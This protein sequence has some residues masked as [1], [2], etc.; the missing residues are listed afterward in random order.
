MASAGYPEKLDG[1]VHE[2][3]RKD[4]PPPSSIQKPRHF[5][6]KLGFYN[7]AVL[8]LG[9]AAVALALAF[10][11]FLWGAATQARHGGPFPELWFKIAEAGWMKQTVTVSSV[12]IR[13]A[14]A[15]QLGVFAAILAALILERV[16]V[17]TE[18]LPKMSMIRCLNSG[19]HSLALSIMN[20]FFSGALVPYAMLVFLAILDAFAMQFTSTI[21]LVDFANTNVVRL[22][23]PTP[24]LFGITS[25]ADLGKSANP[26]GGNDY[27]KSAPLNYP[28]F[29]E[30]KEAGST[31]ANW[32]DTGKTYRGFL[33][34]RE[35]A[36]R[37]ALRNYTGPMMVVDTRV[38][39]VKPTISNI[40][41]DLSSDFPTFE[42]NGTD[43]ELGYSR[44]K[45]V[46]DTNDVRKALGATGQTLTPAERGLFQ[47]HTVSN[48][49]AQSTGV[50]YN[51]TGLDF[52]MD[53]IQKINYMNEEDA[54]NVGDTTFFVE[55]CP[56][57]WS[58]H[59]TH[60]TI[61][62][63]ILHATGNPALVVQSLFTILLQ[64]AYYDFL[65]EYDLTATAN[66]YSEVQVNVPVQWTA[67]A[68]VLAMLFIHFALLTI[69]VV[70]FLTRTEM[71]L[72]GNSWQAV[73]QVMS[74]DTANVVQHGATASD[75]EVKRSMKDSGIVEGKIRI[76]KSVHSGRTE[77]TAVRQR[78]GAMYS[79]PAGHV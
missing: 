43:A 10:L 55:Y 17:P 18:D 59:R 68:G 12:V 78:H 69:A 62:Q 60:A 1:N 41:V 79:T 48:W 39:C 50:V 67:F 77:A 7:L 37:D 45:G 2:T 38:V 20:S 76:T 11:C 63:E 25:N 22:Q 54:L 57:D 58:M 16:G 73:S 32:V 65:P 5:W 44:T 24:I 21:L 31:G 13:V 36:E 3:E 9:T 66:Y 64:M 19:P 15:A 49:T 26:Y 71:S 75:K 40:S 27:W 74:T 56:P 33:P 14:T 47:L 52:L 53:S 6:E 23:E 29:A 42:T 72:L 61:L 4:T 51:K 46:Y 8:I 30:Y 70:L 35:A 34:F 28:R